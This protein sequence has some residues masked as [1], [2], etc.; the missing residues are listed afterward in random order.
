MIDFEKLI[1]NYLQRETK[2]KKIGIYYPSEIGNCLRKIWF[3]YKKP[4][5]LDKEKIKVLQ[6]GLMLHDF[7]ADVLRSEKNQD[8]RLLDSEVPFKI[9][10]SEFSISGRVDDVLI[11][12]KDQKKILV[13]V[14]SVKMLSMAKEPSLP[15]LMQIQ[16]YMYALGIHDGI[17]LYVEKPSLKIKEFEVKYDPE[18]IKSIIERFKLLHEH[19]KS[20][21]IP[22]AEAK[23]LKHM[24]WMCRY[25]EYVEECE[26]SKL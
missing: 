13:E 20:D 18:M 22:N 9:D 23:E 8:V 5:Q 11:V 17:I 15:H 19:L 6:V 21:L 4:K 12:E 2:E 14:K 1:D 25:C 3:T 7:I 16:L 24:E 10:F 26:K